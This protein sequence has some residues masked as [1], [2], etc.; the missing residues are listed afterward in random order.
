M[1]ATRRWAQ[2]TTSSPGHAAARQPVDVAL[3][4]LGGHVLAVAPADM[5]RSMA[6]KL[7][8][9]GIVDPTATTFPFHRVAGGVE[10]LVRFIDA[11]PAQGIVYPAR[12]VFVPVAIRVGLKVVEHPFRFPGELE[13][14]EVDGASLD[15]DP[16]QRHVADRRGGLLPSRPCRWR[17]GIDFARTSLLAEP[18]HPL[19]LVAD[20][21]PR[22]ELAVF[23][24]A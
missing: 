8:E 23:A 22:L 20:D 5:W 3:Q 14:Y 1:R 7:V 15:Q 21:L 9:A 13:L 12:Q 2:A 18:H 17:I 16:L 10:R 11:K 19:T 6:G 4:C 24:G